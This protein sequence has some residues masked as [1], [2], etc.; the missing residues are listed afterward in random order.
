[1][2][3]APITTDVIRRLRE[4]YDSGP[5]RAASSACEEPERIWEA[6]QGTLDPARVGQLLDHANACTACARA[7]QLAR[8]LRRQVPE[9]ADPTVAPVRPARRWMR[10]PALTGAML[11]A[12][13]AV[14][15]VVVLRKE[16]PPAQR[17][18]REASSQSIVPLPGDDH[19]PRDRFLLRWSGGGRGT[20]YELW[21]TTPELR[22]IY[23]EGKLETPEARVPASALEG[24]PRGG[25]V[26]WR[27]EARL[28][29]GGHVES[30]ASRTRVE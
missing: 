6:V 5:P 1:M 7:F 10:R 20:I 27:V 9:D 22:E 17:V 16:E 30:P 14:A 23:R 18:L 15:A 19:L 11:A 21:V 12:A 26:L 8:E 13:A 2:S 24:L 3:D 4:A 29:D 28:P 25:A